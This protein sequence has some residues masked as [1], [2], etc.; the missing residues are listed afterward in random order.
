MSEVVIIKL[1]SG[2]EVVA[3]VIS[4]SITKLEVR[5]PR[6]IHVMQ[7]EQGMGTGLSP[8]IVLAPDSNCDIDKS[9]IVTMITAESQVAK[10][11]LQQTTSIQ[12]LG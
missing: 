4:D 6:M 5:K 12:L 9:H 3:E 11:Y 10:A 2:E 1:I 8:W 7:T